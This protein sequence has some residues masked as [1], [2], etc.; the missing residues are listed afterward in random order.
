MK[1]GF[2]APLSGMLM[3]GTVWI[4][5]L[6]NRPLFWFCNCS[7]IRVVHGIPNYTMLKNGLPIIKSYSIVGS[8]P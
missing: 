1:K 3:R 6:S 7:S 8:N 4:F 5:L 2:A